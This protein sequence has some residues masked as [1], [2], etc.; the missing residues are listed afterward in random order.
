[1]KQSYLSSDSIDDLGRMLTA[2][3]T[4]V[5]VMRDRMAVT[6]Y[7][8]QEKAGLSSADI[9]AFVPPP[10]FAGELQRLRDRLVGNVVG[11]PAAAADRTV[12]NILKSAGIR[13]PAS[14]D[15]EWA[16]DVHQRLPCSAVSTR[17][18]LRGRIP[19]PTR[20]RLSKIGRSPI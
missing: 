1:M 17:P 14:R 16:A 10:A 11:A 4:E 13:P 18:E 20:S 8:L 5:W 12:D 2:L 15:G 3:L 9:D 6:E 7:L 19:P